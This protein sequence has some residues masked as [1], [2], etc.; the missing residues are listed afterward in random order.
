MIGKNY[1]THIFFICS[2]LLYNCESGSGD[3]NSS[4]TGPGVG[5]DEPAL[6]LEHQGGLDFK[7]NAYDYLKVCTIYSIF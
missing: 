3:D 2:I 5:T 4:P 6:A 1:L 7:L